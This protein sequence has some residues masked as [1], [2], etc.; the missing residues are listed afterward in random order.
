MSELRR[1]LQH[2]GRVIAIF[3]GHVH[4][5]TAGHVGRIPATVM[6]SIATTLRKGDYP[7]K[8]DGRPIYLLHRF[9]P[10][11][12]FVTDT[13]IVGTRSFGKK[14]KK[15]NRQVKSVP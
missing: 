12:G 2:T 13:R 15:P 6:T 5:N 14:T 4:R 10:A 8:A 3:S 11:R 1:A 7:A 9:D